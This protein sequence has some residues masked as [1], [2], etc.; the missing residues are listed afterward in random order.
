M[1]VRRLRRPRHRGPALNRHDI[2]TAVD[3]LQHR[4]VNYDERAAPPFH[5]RGWHQDRVTG[6]VG[7]DPPGDERPGGVMDAARTLVDGYAFTDPA[8]L[9]AAY[10]PGDTLLGRNMLLEGRFLVLRFLF[11][12]RI[13]ATHD[14]VREGPDGP[15]HAV[16][17]SYQT[18]V[19]HL[20]QGRLTYEVIKQ[21][22]TGHVLFRIDAYSRR[23]E[24]DNPVVE[25]G[26]RGFGRG[27][28]RRFYRH[29]LSRMRRLI[30]D[31]PPPP[32]PD[33][34]GIVHAPPG[35]GPRRVA[36]HLVTLAH[37]GR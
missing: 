32:T 26:F 34:D 3:E 23:A 33:P 10:R 8:I 19:G 11:G 7:V 36:R 30:Q 35:S 4:T 28:Q 14:D 2:T 27:T 31:P 22:R 37:P 6:L 12:V 9:R 13:T 17:W 29:A 24:I 1:A 5:T 25:L 21:L 15:E 18:L 16:G 20:E